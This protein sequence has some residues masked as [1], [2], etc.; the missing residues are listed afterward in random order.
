MGHPQ[1][2][3][4]ALQQLHQRSGFFGPGQGKFDFRRR[5]PGPACRIRCQRF[6]EDPVPVLRIVEAGDGF[7]ERGGRE[8]GQL[9]GKAAEGHGA[10]V[11]I[12]RRFRRLQTDG[13]LHKV[14]D[15]PEGAVRPGQIR[16]AVSGGHQMQHG[17]GIVGMFGK[18]RR[19]GGDIL[20]QRRH[21]PEHM[22]VDFLKNVAPSG[23]GGQKIGFVDVAAAVALTS[24]G[25]GVQREAVGDGTKFVFHGNPPCNRVKDACM[26]PRQ[27]GSGQ[28]F[29]RDW[30]ENGKNPV[31][32]GWFSSRSA[33]KSEGGQP[34]APL[35]ARLK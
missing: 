14:V 1:G 2:K 34:T 21:I 32:F 7:V 33:A 19:D 30:M 22:V 20:H 23:N 5:L 26:I 8:V 10:F 27:V 25:R 28:D 9:L 18:K 29:R 24:G 15:P 17:P 13:I 11:K 3:L 35:K 6:P 16:A 31:Y 4:A 12:R